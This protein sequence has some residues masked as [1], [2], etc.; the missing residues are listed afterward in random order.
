MKENSNY[1]KTAG[2]EI[3]LYFIPV[4]GLFL[5]WKDRKGLSNLY[6]ISGTVFGIVSLIILINEIV[7]YNLI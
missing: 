7:K 5:L 3:L 1:E 2:M 6:M 4:I